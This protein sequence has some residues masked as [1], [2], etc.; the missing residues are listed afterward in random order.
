ME[1]TD[2]IKEE[3]YHSFQNVLKHLNDIMNLDK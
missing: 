3:M 1:L 2:E